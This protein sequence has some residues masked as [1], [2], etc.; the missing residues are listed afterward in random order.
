MSKRTPAEMR[1]VDAEIYQFITTNNPTTVF[2]VSEE[3]HL[4]R[5]TTRCI[6]DRMIADGRLDRQETIYRKLY[7]IPKT[8]KDLPAT[9]TTTTPKMVSKG[10]KAARKV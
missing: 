9:R 8:V 5:A 6:M 3:L 7:S 2:R 4:P 1:Q 10:P